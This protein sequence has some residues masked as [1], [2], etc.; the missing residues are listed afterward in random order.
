[1]FRA[2]HVP[3]LVFRPPLEL[4]A[5]D[6]ARVAH[7]AAAAL[8]TFDRKLGP[9]TGVV[10]SSVST[11]GSTRRRRGAMFF[12]CTLTPSPRSARGPKSPARRPPDVRP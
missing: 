5:R 6:R 8:E 1:M 9:D 12:F 7:L 10:V 2:R 11:V 4:R 3:P